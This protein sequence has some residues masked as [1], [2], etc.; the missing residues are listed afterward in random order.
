MLN[1]VFEL[2]FFSFVID[3]SAP[4]LSALFPNLLP[5]YFFPLIPTK[6]E[7]FFILFEFIDAELI[8]F[9]ILITFDFS[10]SFKIFVFIDFD[11]F[12]FFFAT[13]FKI[14]SLSEK[15]FFFYTLGNFRDPF[16]PL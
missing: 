4:F 1:I 13:D 12:L 5:S 16:L 9:L 11:K 7:L 10:V 6:I 3:K 14:S 15:N 8:I 2:R